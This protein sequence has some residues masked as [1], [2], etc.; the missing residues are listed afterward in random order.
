M[1]GDQMGGKHDAFLGDLSNSVKQDFLIKKRVLSFEEYFELALA[2]PMIHARNAAQYLVDCFRYFG[3]EGD[4]FQLFD[5]PFEDGLDH[6]VGQ[7]QSQQDVF[8]ILSKFARQGKVDHLILLHGPNGSAKSTLISCLF[9][10]LEFYSST[11]EGA[12]YRFNW[13][14]PIERY[15]KKGLG[16]GGSD[17]PSP[18]SYAFLE[19]SEI[20]TKIQTDMKDHPL[21][22]L[23]KHQRRDLLQRR[24]GDSET[25][26]SDSIRDGDLSPMNRLIFDALLTSYN[27]DLERVYQHV[28]VERFFLSSRFRRGLVTVEPQLEVDASLR[29]ITLDRSLESLPKVLQNMT[30]FEP[31][32][33][34]VDANRGAVEFNDLLKRPVETF[35]YLLS[36]C[37]KSTVT[38]PSAILYLDTVFVASSNDRYVNAFKE[39]PEWPS[40][41]G[42]I[43][44]VQVPYLLDYTKEAGIY[45]SQVRPESVGKHISPHAMSVAGL[46]AVLTRLT[47]PVPE[48]VPESLKEMTGK[49]TPLEKADMYALGRPPEWA[50][51]DR[52][53]DLPAITEALREE[54][55]SRSPYEGQVGA[56][57]RE[58]K[59]ILFDAAHDSDYAC[60]SPLAVLAGLESLVKDLSIY[61]FLRVEPD[62]G[63][64]DHP[65][66]VQA[67]GARYL[68]W[69]DDDVRLSM[70]LAAEGQYEDLIARYTL[71]V[72]QVLKK[73]KVRNPVTGKLEDPDTRFLEE[74][75]T[76]LGVEGKRDDFRQEVMG[77]IGAWSLDN[78]GGGVPYASLFHNLIETL[79]EGF[80]RRHV[81]E[82]RLL[83]SQVLAHLVGEKH[84]LTTGEKARVTEVAAKLRSRGY[85]DECAAELLSWVL[86]EKYPE[87]S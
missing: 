85:C 61:E 80:F 31:F 42:R 2:Q 81:G 67:V 72:N 36:T 6:L 32:G 75:E 37:E 21:F 9:R 59:A 1:S 16:F 13:V 76:M 63:F 39:F 22:L 51:V 84:N 45:D 87:G 64:Q 60:L 5:V 56:S 50:R 10:A 78:A 46:F 53:S 73:E 3:V 12:L 17:R 47:R 23:P 48:S 24:F 82:I 20:S 55:N 74:V 11:E 25:P 83:G 57:P 43:E 19:E 65:A 33:D 79:R 7:E 40:F 15:E 68:E 77:T 34:L 29:Q 54:G 62:G 58:I 41:K 52:A 14:F 49:L 27:G 70:G 18:G 26:L 71:H 30:L 4:R 28:Q 66:L 35:K 44:L 86:R 69:A 8:R 38:L